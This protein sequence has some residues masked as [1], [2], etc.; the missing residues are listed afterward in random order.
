[1]NYSLEIGFDEDLFCNE[2][3]VL[4]D[5]EKFYTIKKE[6]VIKEKVKSNLNVIKK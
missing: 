1:M 4:K 2:N 5:W 6:K 3:N